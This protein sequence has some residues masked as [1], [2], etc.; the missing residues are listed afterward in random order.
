MNVNISL[1]SLNVIE[2]EDEH[3][4]WRRQISAQI[5]FRQQLHNLEVWNISISRFICKLG[6]LGDSAATLSLRLPKTVMLGV[7]F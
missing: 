3:L 7:R 4:W 5:C 1:A 6:T 2:K